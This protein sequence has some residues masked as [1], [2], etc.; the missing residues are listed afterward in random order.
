MRD[1]K[2]GESMSKLIKQPGHLLELPNDRVLIDIKVFE[3]GKIQLQ[4]PL[5]DPAYV[6]KMLG[7]IIVDVTYAALK[8]VEVPRIDTS[9]GREEQNDK[10]ETN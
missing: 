4:A 1:L 8:P 9:Q 2:K 10:T 5:V 3:S 6:C 7:N